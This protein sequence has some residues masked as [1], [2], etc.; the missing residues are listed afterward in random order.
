MQ[1]ELFRLDEI[2][3]RG[4][5]LDLLK[6][7]WMILLGAAAVWMA[8]TGIH[9]MIYDPAYTSSATLV[10]TAKGENS[11][12]ASLSTA[13]SMA[14]VFGQ[15]FQSEALRDRIISDVGEEIEGS[16]SC[17]PISET[18]LL[19][20]SVTSPDPRQ[21]YLFINSA[22]TH[23]EDVASDVFSNAALQIVQE[24]EV[25][26]FPSNTSWF[27]ANRNLLTVLGAV[28]AAAVIMLFYLLRMTVKNAAAAERQLDGKVR[29][30]I[31]YEKKEQGE[32]IRDLL[33]VRKEKEKRNREA[34]KKNRVKSV[35]ER[36]KGKEALLLTVPTV[37]MDFA[38]ACR[39]A[40]TRVEAHMRKRHQQI[41]LVTSV[42]ENEGKSTVAANLALAMAE[43]HRKVLLL[44]GD[45]RKPAQYK[46][47]EVK[48][49]EK[50]REE[51]DSLRSLEQVLQGE[52]S[53]KD[54][55]YHNKKSRIW[56]ILQFR[57]A[58]SPEKLIDRF[59]T[60]NMVSE[61]R[62]AFDYIIIDC[63][64]AAVST[65]AE[66]WLAAVDTVLLVVREDWADVRVINDTV[67]MI[68]QSGTDFAGFILNAFHKDWMQAGTDYGYQRYSRKRG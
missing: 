11:T 31:P 26:E 62:E 25:P 49:R 39:R 59:V 36:K 14:D 50:S 57:N 46:V 54:A 33:D 32:G 65:D 55:V 27:L 56:Q 42:T 28:G 1:R 58:A 52:I 43:K 18:N 10:V 5:C 4:L 34:R 17:V 41:L 47:F 19:V 9:N 30:V 38:E 12:Y 21:A 68:W 63:S 48:N 7:L 64:P 60:G 40:E 20:L 6:N 66:N 53:W 15:V 16:I 3:V 23:Y 61:M 22:L 24:P 13:A 29:G 2:S 44:D 67:D 51:K 45:L 37:T 35:P 8:A